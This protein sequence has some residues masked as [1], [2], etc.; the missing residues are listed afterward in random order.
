M[1]SL[2]ISVAVHDDGPQPETTLDKG[3]DFIFEQLYT[4]HFKT[5]FYQ[6]LSGLDLNSEKLQV[7]PGCRSQICIQGFSLCRLIRVGTSLRG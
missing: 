3:L 7:A 6:I 2:M 1:H 5:R 4:F